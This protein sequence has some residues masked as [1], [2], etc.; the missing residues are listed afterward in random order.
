MFH[1]LGQEI[2]NALA[3]KLYKSAAII[4]KMY[5]PDTFQNLQK[6]AT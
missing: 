2:L 4:F 6:E 3:D 5:L 1:Y